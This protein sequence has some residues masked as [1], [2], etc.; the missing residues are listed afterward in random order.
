MVI[1]R[2]SRTAKKVVARVRHASAAK[3]ADTLVAAVDEFGKL[4]A[5]ISQLEE[6]RN[7]LK[8]IMKTKGPGE[9]HGKRFKVVVT[10]VKG[11]E[12]LVREKVAEFLTVGQMA[13]CIKVGEDSLQIRA[14]D[15]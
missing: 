10:P 1:D 4:S 12:T 13:Q 7:E 6:R 9:I 2:K 3:P 15:L 14:Y 5:Q 11:R 8:E